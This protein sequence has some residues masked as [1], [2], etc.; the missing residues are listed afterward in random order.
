MRHG[1]DGF[2]CPPKEGVLRTFLLRS[3]SNPRTWVSKASTLPL[4]HRS[5]ELGALSSCNFWDVISYLREAECAKVTKTSLS[6]MYKEWIP[7]YCDIIINTPVQSVVKCAFSFKLVLCFEGLNT[8]LWRTHC[9]PKRWVAYMT[10]QWQSTAPNSHFE[11]R[12]LDI[13][14][15]HKLMCRLV[16]S[17]N[18][19]FSHRDLYLLFS[20]S[21]SYWKYCSCCSWHIHLLRTNI[22]L[23]IS[24]CKIHSN[25]PNFIWKQNVSLYSRRSYMFRP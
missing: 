5:R 4:D 20:V 18:E 1:T 2:T 15:S 22:L 17:I 3:G 19:M 14:H 13:K 12:S 9:L 7:V 16:I 6:W 21:V 8:A 24:D 10:I 23:Y 25:T 11:L